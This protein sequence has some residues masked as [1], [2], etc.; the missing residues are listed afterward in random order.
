MLIF[1][2][3]EQSFFTISYREL[4]RLDSV[5]RSPIYALLGESVDGVAVIRAFAAQKSLLC[6]LTD[7][8]DIQQHAYFLTCAAQSWLAVR[9]ELIGTLIV[10]FAALSAVLE[11]TRSGA[12]GTFAGLA[13]LSIS[14]A[15]SVTQ[16][17][18][19]SVRM[20]SDME[21]NMVAVERV[22][23]YSNI[24]SE[25][26][27]STPVDAKLPQVWPP[28]GAIEFTE[29]RLRYRPGLPFVLKGLNLTIPPGS[30]IGVVGRTG[31]GKSTLMIA[32]MRIVD[33]TEGTIKID[34]TDISEIGLARLRRT[35]AVI[36]QD[37]VL[38]SGSVRSNLDPFHEYE[39]DAL[40]DILDRVGLYARSRT[41][42]TQSLPSLGQICI[43]TLT[44]VIAEGGINFSVGQRQ[45]LVIARALLRGAKI[46]IMDEATAA[47]DAGTDAAIQKVIR[48]E[49][50]EA[51]CITVAH[52]INTILDSD[53]ILV[54]SDG[55]AE[56]FDKPDMLLKKGGLFRD[57][58]RA[59][60]D[61]T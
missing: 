1:Y 58:V 23:E 46:V 42:S 28:K 27:R 26:L 33:V 15:L 24:Q 44:D 22:E 4:K 56:E 51:T 3:K 10:T 11:H 35:L 21:A 52:R 59:S 7:M 20:A 32:L 31:A 45:L 8:L 37:P 55:K 54:M 50:T 34:G 60:A 43:R 39:D 47:V 30:K 36:P 13:G 61:N 16:S 29:V 49:F 5:S 6:R 12:D 2:L 53:Y 40:L 17:L 18:N 25:G 48:T 14:Y 57:L 19:W 38:F 9:L 41:S